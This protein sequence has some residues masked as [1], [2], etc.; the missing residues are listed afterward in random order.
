MMQLKLYRLFSTLAGPLIDLYLMR[1]K[2]IGKEDPKRFPERL[3]HQGFP[4]PAG[5]LIWVHAASVGESISILPL[6]TKIVERYTDV[7]ILLTTGTVTSARMLENRLPNRVF[8]QYVPIDRPITVRRFLTSW[9]P[10]LALWVES[11]LWPNLIIETHRTGCPMIQVNARISVPSFEK[12]HKYS[13]LARKMLAC[14]S[15]SLAQSDEDKERLAKLGARNAKCVG[16]LKFDAP[17][18][19]ADPAETGKLVGM[20]G[21]RPIW[22]AASTHPGEE[23][24][25][26]E[27]HK[28]LKERH[29][30]LLTILIPRHPERGKELKSSLS[31]YKVSLRSQEDEITSET[32][33]YIADTIGELGIFYRLAGIVFMGGSLVEHGGQNPLEPAR[34]DCALI[35]GPNISNFLRIYKELEDHKAVIIVRDAKEL[36]DQVDHLL[37]DHDYQE[38]MAAKTLSL[39]ESKQGVMDNYLHELA[40]YLKSLS[41]SGS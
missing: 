11:E 25:I 35:T 13:T 30:N 31:R 27:A 15:L 22:V 23:E 1:R 24:H 17:P 9:R 38:D 37:I 3:G 19:P 8:H 32:D 7:H 26:M 4:R 5:S 34:L 18:L 2:Q 36:A 41:K 40:P 10:D 12:W 6:I 28:T 21:D 16:N 33:V 14:F 39:M 20:I 29:D